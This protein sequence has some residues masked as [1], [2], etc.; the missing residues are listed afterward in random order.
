MHSERR[1]HYCLNLGAH[2][3]GGP[4][5]ATGRLIDEA[6]IE[7]LPVPGRLTAVATSGVLQKSGRVETYPLPVGTAEHI[8]PIATKGWT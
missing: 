3:F 8:R 1:G 4:A 5:T 6:G 2:V 7:A